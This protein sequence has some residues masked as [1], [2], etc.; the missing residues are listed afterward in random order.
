MLEARLSAAQSMDTM[1]LQNAS[2]GIIYF[3]Q[4]CLLLLYQAIIGV[5]SWSELPC[6][7]AGLYEVS[8]QVSVQD[9]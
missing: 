4:S 1:H 9:G 6:F 2:E 8:A 7:V 3:L 5:K